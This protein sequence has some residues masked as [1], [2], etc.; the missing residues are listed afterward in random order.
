M[1]NKLIYIIIIV[2]LNNY[3]SNSYLLSSHLKGKT[4][5]LHNFVIFS[6]NESKDI[7]SNDP[8][9]QIRN[10]F[11]NKEFIEAYQVLKRNPLA[12]L[13]IDDGKMFLNNLEALYSITNDFETNQKQ[14]IEISEFLYKRFERQ[15][16]LRGFGSAEY[17]EKST[18]EISPQ[19]LEELTGVSITSLT[20]KQRNTY[21]QFAGIALC[22]VEYAIASNFGIDPTF[23]IIPATLLLLLSDQ[24]FLKGAVFE[25][26]Y[27]GI[28]P[29]YKDKVISHEA[30]HFLLAYLLGVPIRGVATSA[31]EARKYPDIQGQAGTIFYDTKLANEMASSKVTRT[32]LDR[33]SVIV[34]AGIAAEALKFQK[35]EGGAVDE[36]SLIE[37]F[38]S[39]QPPWNILRIQSQARWAAVQAILL[40]KE[41]QQS[42]DAIV[43]ALEEKK[44]MGDVIFAL[45]ENLPIVLPSQRRAEQRKLSQREEEIDALMKYI[46]RMTWR[47]GGIYSDLTLEDEEFGNDGLLVSRK[48]GTTADTLSS[49]ISNII[50]SKDVTVDLFKEKIQLIQDS[51]KNGKLPLPDLNSNT[52]TTTNGGIW[53]NNLD[54]LESQI[55]TTNTNTNTDTGTNT[56]SN[57]ETSTGTSFNVKLA[58]PIDGFQERIEALQKTGELPM[59][60]KED[61]LIVNASESSI[62]LMV[63]HAT[64][65]NVINEL[66]VELMLKNHIGYQMKQLQNIK[67][68]YNRK[69]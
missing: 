12:Q 6:N 47:V 10:H 52:N 4:K 13:S 28:K 57:K 27:R 18:L 5:I 35:A 20:P 60:G 42:Y 63:Q 30:G 15:H 65:D 41:H 33:L 58:K 19:R 24:I 40:I 2:I 61:E 64:N 9:T 1:T 43:H 17:P 38:S 48:I 51:I 34:M 16:L 37:L 21:W 68:V 25:T 23:S 55:P 32:S 45:E 56:N 50:E 29:E 49:N 59:E 44:P 26:I 36:K 3:Y 69:V 66:S 14:S 7:N 11:N 39:I 62:P 31:W 46:Q 67:V 22:S 8:I 54:S 53:L